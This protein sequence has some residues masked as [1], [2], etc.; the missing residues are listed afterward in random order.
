M[1]RLIKNQKAVAEKYDASKQYTLYEACEL[2]KEIT[3]TK[4]DASVEVSANLA[5]TA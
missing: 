1:S 5:S 4:F 3:Y 2:L